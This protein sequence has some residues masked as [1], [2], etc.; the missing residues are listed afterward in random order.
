MTNNERRLRNIVRVANRQR[1]L[2]QALR[3]LDDKAL[4]QRLSRYTGFTPAEV[5]RQHQRLYQSGFDR[6]RV[7]ERIVT[8]EEPQS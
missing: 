4:C 2:R 1:R 7:I 3:R 8:I 5:K 6:D